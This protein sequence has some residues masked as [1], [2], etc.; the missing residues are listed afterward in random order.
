MD[1]AKQHSMPHIHETPP[2][3]VL[4]HRTLLVVCGP[5]GS[6]KSTFA[7]A[8]VAAHQEQGLRDTTIVSSDYCRALVCDDENN[9][10]A[11]RDA[12]DLFFYLIHKRMFQGVFTIA[13]STALQD[14]VRRRL[15][16]LAQRHHYYTCLFVF[17]TTIETC[18]QRDRNRER[19]VGEQVILYHRRLLQQ[20]LLDIANEPWNQ[21]AIVE[22]QQ[23]N[24]FIRI[25]T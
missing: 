5:A 11:S 15:L 2:I 9:Q 1:D 20:A 8:I 10:R 4:P 18:I 7:R 13:D 24:T 25:E 3:I 22:E 23:S 21:Y 17:N 19:S 6:G 12:F 16:E 14:H